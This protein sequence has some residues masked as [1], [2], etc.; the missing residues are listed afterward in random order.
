MKIL[1]YILLGAAITI[2]SSCGESWLDLEPSTQIPTDTAIQNLSHVEYSLNSIYNV[3]RNAY[4]YSGRMTYYGDVTGDD[5]QANGLTK[6]TANYYLMGMT[7]DTGP[8]T[9]WS[10][11]YQIIRN[12]NIILSQIDNLEYD[13]D[14]QDEFND[15]K[16]QALLLRGMAHFELTRFFGYPY[17]KDNGASLGVPIVHEVVGVDYKPSRN[18]VAECYDAFIADF[19]EAASL[20]SPAFNKGKVNKWTAMGYLSR[21]YLYMG[22]DADAL[23]MAIATINGA[24]SNKYALWSNEEYPTIWASDIDASNPGEILFEMV[25]TTTE[26]PGK[27]SMGYLCYSSGY[28]DMILTSS[29]YQL[30]T[31]DANDVRAKMFTIKSK[32]AYI[33]KYQAQAGE[34]IQD[35]NIPVM[36]LSEIYLIAAEAAAK[37]QNRNET[38]VQYLNAIVQRANPENSVEGET[39][40]LDRVLLER[41]K[42]L[43]GEG[44]RMFD[45]IRNNRRIERTDVSVSAISST[46]HYELLPESK[47]FDWTYFRVVLPIPKA[48]MNANPNLVQNPEYGTN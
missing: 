18:T 39:I 43:F 35:A 5:V 9:H 31:E 22:R 24:E 42:E 19:E 21:A 32:K 25:N 14:E 33:N 17:T 6:R 47:S 45:A 48:E 38:A 7:R 34:N 13:N 41:R 23:N 12:C 20:L 30:L 27:E 8:S 26:S 3:M 37:L 28:S 16:G 40:T 46:S 29:F 1:K 15:L 36:R 4:Y 2:T 11:A 10:Y 44:H